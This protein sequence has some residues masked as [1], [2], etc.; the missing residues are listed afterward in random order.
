MTP[1]LYASGKGHVA[2]I[3]ML[4]TKGADVNAR[5]GTYSGHI[6]AMEL[7]ILKGA[8]VNACNYNGRRVLRICEAKKEVVEVLLRHG[9]IG[10]L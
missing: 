4:I 8:D 2:A 5:G 9:A 1:L 7:L 3:E 10:S 6:N